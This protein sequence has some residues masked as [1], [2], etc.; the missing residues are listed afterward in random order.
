MPEARVSPAAVRAQL[1][2]SMKYDKVTPT[3]S[4]QEIFAMHALVG[5]SILYICICYARVRLVCP[6]FTF[7]F[8]IHTFGWS[9]HH[10]HLHLRIVVPPTA[11]LD[12]E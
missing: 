8:A 6:S 10:V 12:Q 11:E 3:G 4:L 2:F 5:L 7:A 1:D 9:V